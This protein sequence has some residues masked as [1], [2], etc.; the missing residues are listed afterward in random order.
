V[1]HQKFSRENLTGGDEEANSAMI[2]HSKSVSSYRR[3]VMG[4]PLR[5]LNHI[6]HPKGTPL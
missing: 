6:S 3:G 1:L 4:A 2:D 5:S